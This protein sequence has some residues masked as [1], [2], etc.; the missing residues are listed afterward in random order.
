[1]RWSSEVACQ[2]CLGDGEGCQLGESVY[3]VKPEDK[4]VSCGLVQK[5]LT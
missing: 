5:L 3:G 4:S 1:M 2:G